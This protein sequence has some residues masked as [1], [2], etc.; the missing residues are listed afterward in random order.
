M[1]ELF[2]YFSYMCAAIFVL[3]Y[4]Y[5]VYVLKYPSEEVYEEMNKDSVFFTMRPKL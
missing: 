1:I 5:Y 2:V 3:K 4:V